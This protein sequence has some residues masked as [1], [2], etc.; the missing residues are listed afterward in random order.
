MP[1]RGIAQN[2]SQLWFGCGRRLCVE[3]GG[4]ISLFGLAEGL[5]EDAWDAIG[6]TP[7]GSVWIRS[8]S[9]LY[10]KPP[11]ALRLFR[12][13]PTIASS[14]F[15]GAL[16]VA[17]DGSVMIPTD[18]G[19]AICSAG[20]WSVV[21]VQRGLPA[22]MTSAVLEDR[23]GSLWIALIGSGVARWLGHGEW[24]AWTKAQGLPSDLIWSIR[25]DRKGALWV[26]TSLGLARMDDRGSLRTW[27]RK[28]GLGAILFT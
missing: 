11:G 5:P 3:D 27:T 16:T 26:G 17:R 14:I 25:R 2:G 13:K 20:N 4:R 9:N 6:I 22:A 21:D 7:D 18:K 23:D 24:E 19:L 1:V 12:E 28:D 10:R 15:W 8:P